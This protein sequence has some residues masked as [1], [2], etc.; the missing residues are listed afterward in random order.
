MDRPKDARGEN[1]RASYA[2]SARRTTSSSSRSTR[3]AAQS[4]PSSQNSSLTDTGSPRVGQF[5]PSKP[6]AQRLGD[7]RYRPGSR[8][9]SA[10]PLKASWQPKGEDDSGEAPRRPA[11]KKKPGVGRFVKT[12]GWRV[13]ALPILVVITVLVVVNTA[14]SPAEPGSSAGTGSSESAVGDAAAGAIDGGQAIPENPAKPVDVN[15]PTAELPA[16]GNFTEAGKGTWHVVP[17][18]GPVVGKSGKLYTYTV[19]VEDGIDP[20]SYAGDDSF[21]T[22][23]QGI[24]SDPRSWTWNGEIRLQRVDASYPDP[25]FRVSLTSPNTTHRADAC[26]FQ[27]KFEASCYRRSM[28]RVLI[29]LARWVRGAMV[30]GADMTGYRQYA[31]N[32]EVG[33]ALGNIHV[34]CPGNSQP[35]PVMMQQ[36]FGVADDY[37]AMLNNIPGGDKGKVAS[38]HHTCVPNAWPNPTP[39]AQ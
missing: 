36:S 30:Y 39:R 26:G 3:T 17:G 13:Y 22:A 9:T 24:L 8:R 7:D 12:Y 2:G 35:A 29:N 11:A 32:H 38:D 4:S 28:G 14:T 25:S 33:H 34:G 15:V 37:V 10:E 5:R 31:I 1:R 18:S 27:I 16:G 21:A 19:E 20:A 23:V 6:P